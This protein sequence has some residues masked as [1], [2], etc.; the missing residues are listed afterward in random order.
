MALHSTLVWNVEEARMRRENAMQRK[1][2]ALHST[3]VWNVEEGRVW[4]THLTFPLIFISVWCMATHIYVD[5]CS[6]Q[7][8]NP[9]PM[10]LDI[11]DSPSQVKI[12]GDQIIHHVEVD[13]CMNVGGE[14]IL[15]QRDIDEFLVLAFQ[16][17]GADRVIGILFGAI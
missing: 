1:K 14:V 4:S 8:H 16:G 12:L 2:M 3:L 15:R 5:S 7:L 9:M 11:H 17:R 13:G 10:S 6:K